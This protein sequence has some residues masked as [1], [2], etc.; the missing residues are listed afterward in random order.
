MHE[1]AMKTERTRAHDATSRRKAIR[2]ASRFDG[3]F[4]CS[5]HVHS[6]SQVIHSDS[7]VD[8]QARL[9]LNRDRQDSKSRSRNP[10]RASQAGKS[11][12]RAPIE[13]ARTQKVV[14]G[15][16]VEPTK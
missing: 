9:G 4:V 11:Q 5:T 13:P 7:Q 8:S 3:A 10:Q 16:L 1:D 12:S 14:Q 15:A 2:F 6:L